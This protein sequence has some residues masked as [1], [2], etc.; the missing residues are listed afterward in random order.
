MDIR[1][2]SIHFE[3]TERL[4]EF[5]QKRITKLEKFTDTI[6]DVDVTLKVVKPEVSNNKEASVKINSKNGDF[7]AAKVADS[8]E[9]AIDLCSEALE[10]QII[11]SKEKSISK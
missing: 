5:I 2:Q 1:I 3:A 4:H 9:E 6:V 7:F 8:F 10:K 11:K